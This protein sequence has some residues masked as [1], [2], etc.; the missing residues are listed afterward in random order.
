MHPFSCVQLLGCTSAG[1][2]RRPATRL[3]LPSFFS[4]GKK[5][6]FVGEDEGADVVAGDIAGGFEHIEERIDTE[7]EGDDGGSLGGREIKRIEDE[8]EEENAS[9]GDAACADGG[10]DD[11]KNHNH[12]LHGSNAETE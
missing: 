12:Q 6:E 3:F 10:E 8:E 9:A 4:P 1:Q 7:G 5:A 2:Q 11:T